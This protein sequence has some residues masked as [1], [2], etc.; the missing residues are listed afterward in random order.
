[1]VP[2]ASKQR[3]CLRGFLRV[4]S[5]GRR[6]AF[7]LRSPPP[8]GKKLDFF[9]PPHQVPALRADTQRQ[10]KRR[11]GLVEITLVW[12]VHNDKVRAVAHTAETP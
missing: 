4:L 2:D 11:L 7:R 3:E 9:T 10:R 6:N 5:W 1:M 12:S 8:F